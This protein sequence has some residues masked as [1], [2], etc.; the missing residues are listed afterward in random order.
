[1]DREKEID[2]IATTYEPIVKGTIICPSERMGDVMGLITE[3][4]FA[5]HVFSSVLP[6]SASLNKIILIFL[7]LCVPSAE[8]API[9]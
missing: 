8:T 6:F 9:L 3:Y 5:K 4:R 2:D 1:M 7:P